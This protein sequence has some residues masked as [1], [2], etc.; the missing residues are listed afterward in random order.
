MS[1]FFDRY[2]WLR[3]TSAVVVLL[4]TGGFLNFVLQES[5]RLTE[6]DSVFSPSLVIGLIAVL[7]ALCL[8]LFTFRAL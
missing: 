8:T 2:W 3:L 1:P 6:I 7:N 4:V 5:A